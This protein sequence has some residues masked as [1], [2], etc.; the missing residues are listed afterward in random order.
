M[1][2]YES[3]FCLF[4]YHFN[5]IFPCEYYLHYLN[6]VPCHVI[7]NI[8][9]SMHKEMLAFYLQHFPNIRLLCTSYLNFG[10]VLYDYTI[11]YWIFFLRWPTGFNWNIFLRN[12][13]VMDLIIWIFF[14]IY[15]NACNL[16]HYCTTPKISCRLHFGKTLLPHS[17]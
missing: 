16:E 17:L 7:K 4:V 8:S 10:P 5:L 9:G 15:I 11:F 12:S 6:M 3:Y 13:Y 1:E 14:L 2:C